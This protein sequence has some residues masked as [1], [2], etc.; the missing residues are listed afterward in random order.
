M[1]VKI[2]RKE[3]SELMS[4]FRRNLVAYSKRLAS[5]SLV[6]EAVFPFHFCSVQSF[7]Y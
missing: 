7:A 3:I 5:E 2:G 6:V 1:D 4:S